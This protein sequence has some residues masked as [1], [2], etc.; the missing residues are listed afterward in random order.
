MIGFYSSYM[1]GFLRLNIKNRRV[2]HTVLKRPFAP[3]YRGHM[4]ELFDGDVMTSIVTEHVRGPRWGLKTR[5]Y[6]VDV[7]SH[8][9]IASRKEFNDSQIEDAVMVLKIHNEPQVVYHA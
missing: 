5:T 4:Y 6:V 9:H 7:I 2:V 1:A 8:N 3:D